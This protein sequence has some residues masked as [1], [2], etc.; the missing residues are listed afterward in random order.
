[1][2]REQIPLP[3]STSCQ[4]SFTSELLQGQ[5]TLMFQESRKICILEKG[6]NNFYKQQRNISSDQNEI[7]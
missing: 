3:K 7:T 4:G 5:L 1:M 6:V 2:Y